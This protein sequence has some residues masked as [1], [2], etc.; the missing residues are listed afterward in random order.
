[1]SFSG[2]IRHASILGFL[3]ISL[4][5]S[6][7]V[8]PPVTLNPQSAADRLSQG[9]ISLPTNLSAPKSSIPE[10]DCS[11]GEHHGDSINLMSCLDAA[12]ELLKNTD[13]SRQRILTFKDR[14]GP[15]RADLADVML[16]YLSLSC[17][18]VL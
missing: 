5:L 12:H 7:R 9:N 16:P 1:M 17:R 8:P 6:L 13:G 18:V 10:Y 11:G 15:G 14:R 2:V 3:Y 4:S